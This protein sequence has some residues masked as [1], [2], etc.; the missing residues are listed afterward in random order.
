MC[1][2]FSDERVCIVLLGDLNQGVVV[3]VVERIVGRN[4]MLGIYKSCVSLLEM[5][6]E[7]EL[8]IVT[9]FKKAVIFKFTY[10]HE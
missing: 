9:F 10:I 7:Q 4:R 3:E 6:A 8:L 1:W 5:C 2:K